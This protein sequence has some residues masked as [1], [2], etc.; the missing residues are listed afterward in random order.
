VSFDVVAF[1]QDH[2]IPYDLRVNRGWAN[3]QCPHCSDGS[4]NGGWNISQGYY[5][6]WRCGGHEAVFTVSRILRV[7]QVDAEKAL[8]PYEGRTAIL[9]SL[10]RVASKTKIDFPFGPLTKMERKYLKGRGFDPK[11]LQEKYGVASGGIVGPW[12]YRIIIPFF[13]NK[14]VMSYQGRDITGTSK[15]RYKNLAIE[16][17]VQNLKHLIYNIDNCTGPIAHVMEGV[18][19]VWRFGDGFVSTQGTSMDA[20]QIKLL[21]RRFRKV[22]F[23]FDPEVEAQQKAR[24]Y[25]S[26][27][28]V[29]GVEAEIVDLELDHDP[30]DC[31]DEEVESIKRELGFL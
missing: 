16:Q 23:L 11:H 19:D 3:V 15:I 8:S 17:S 27:L 7:N 25:A 12:A 20:A 2:G 4:K 29:L 30:G 10:N 31:S 9:E 18:T 24:R 22:V 21:A 1:L 14:K 6:C 5:H 26:S 28:A 13:V